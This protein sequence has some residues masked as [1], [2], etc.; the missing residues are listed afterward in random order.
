MA[1]EEQIA[2]MPSSR[3]T[4][5]ALTL[6]AAALLHGC[7]RSVATRP[8]QL[9]VALEALG[10]E[11]AVVKM[12]VPQ[13]WTPLAPSPARAEFVGPDRRSRIYLRAMPASPKTQRCDKLARS[14]AAEVIESWGGP[15]RTQVV[16]KKAFEAG[17]DFEL[18]RQ[19]P[20][21][22]GERI[23][24]RVV[25]K[26]GVLAVVSCAGPAPREPA[27]RVLCGDV[28]ASLEVVAGA[29]TPHAAR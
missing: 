28:L 29:Q 10:P 20:K 4:S 3:W 21:P 2:A 1:E 13:G 18:L 22:L 15:P 12:A 16:E 19:D 9:P 7:V 23:W 11:S 24:S 17:V 6:L 25:C 27:L 5:L 8:V 26:S 14:Y